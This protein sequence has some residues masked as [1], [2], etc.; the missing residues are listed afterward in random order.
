MQ[1]S[2][3]THFSPVF[4][5]NPIE[6]NKIPAK[7]YLFSFVNYWY[8]VINDDNFNNLNNLTLL[9]RKTAG[10]NYFYNYLIIL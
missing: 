6:K 3:W 9:F 1:A 4:S 2:M 5:Q 7:S 8:S 10:W